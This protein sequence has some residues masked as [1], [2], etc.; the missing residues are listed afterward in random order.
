M[1]Q[2]FAIRLVKNNL[3]PYIYFSIQNYF[4]LIPVSSILKICSIE[5]HLEI[6]YFGLIN[7]QLNNYQLNLKL[8]NECYLKLSNVKFSK[9]LNFDSI[10]NAST[11]LNYSITLQF[12]TI[13]F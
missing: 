5:I 9:I 7:N 12:K 8:V 6:V 1:F 4:R 2:Y 13:Q 11:T 10:I 3:K